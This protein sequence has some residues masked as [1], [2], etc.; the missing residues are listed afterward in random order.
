LLLRQPETSAAADAERAYEKAAELGVPYRAEA[1]VGVARA[2]LRRELYTEAA[3]AALQAIQASSDDE[4]A[5]KARSAICQ[6]RRAGNLTP[7]AAPMPPAEPAPAI[8]WVVRQGDP[9]PRG[10]GPFR[11]AESVTKP[12]K[13]Y[14]APPV[15]TEEARKQRVQGVV[16]LESII[17]KDGCVAA[18]QILKSLPAGLGY[19]ALA[20]AE[21]W[22]FAPATLEGRPVKVYYT[23]TVN[24]QV[25]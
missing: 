9:S 18:A 25:E 12:R 24:F 22:A 17:D 21:K 5:G 6:A 1:L 13:L 7:E 20:A 2:G 16:I 19:A 4:T 11:V 14:A 8:P 15:Y 23:L 10:E 3:A